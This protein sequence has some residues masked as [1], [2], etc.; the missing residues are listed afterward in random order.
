MAAEYAYIVVF[1]VGCSSRGAAR[2]KRAA[3]GERDQGTVPEIQGN[4]PVAAD[5][6]GTG[7]APQNMRYVCR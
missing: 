5:T 7:G 4:F 6:A 3:D 1:V 2:Q